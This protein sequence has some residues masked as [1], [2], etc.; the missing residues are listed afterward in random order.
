M[1]ILLLSTA[2][3]YVCK[4]IFVEL[5]N[6]GHDVSIELALNEGIIREGVELF[7]PDLVICPI[8]LT[9][10]P[11][12]VYKKVTCIIVHPGIKGDRGPSSLDWAIMDELDEWGVT[13][14]EAS[15]VFDAGDIWVSRN[16]EM[17]RASK[18]SI[19]R[20][21]VSKTAAA[22]A[23]DL[24]QKFERGGFRPEPLDYSKP[25]VKGTWRDPMKQPDRRIDWKSDT[26]DDIRKKINTA[27]GAPGLLDEI[28]GQE[29]FMYGA[30]PEDNMEGPVP[31]EVIAKRNGAICR[32]TVDGAIWITH[33]RKRKLAEQNFYKLPATVPEV[34]V[35][36][37]TSTGKRNRTFREIWYEEKNDV[38]YVYF[39]FYNGAMS[40]DQCIRMRD[41]VLAARLRKIKVIVLMGGRDFWSNGIHLN[42]IHAAQNPGDESW[43]N[44]NAIDDLVHAIITDTEHIIISAIQGSAGAGGVPLAVAADKVFCASSVIMSP[45]YKPMGDLYGSEY[46]TYLLPRRVGK[47]KGV[48]I[49]ETFMPIGVHEA[50]SIGL[51]DE[52]VDRD[53]NQTFRQKIGHMAE[54]IA[55]SPDFP[56]MIE[57]KKQ[58][59]ESDEKEKPLALYRFEELEQMKINFYGKDPAYHQARFNFVRKVVPKETPAFLAKHRR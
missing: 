6:L 54:E 16:F 18:N 58:R 26:I 39:E 44:I 46:W 14:M 10:I 7:K 40:T 23:V 30:H 50:K 33:L 19:Y 12:D 34:P 41:A 15:E 48:E 55:R 28:Y 21:E 11:E 45:F 8:L 53:E 38:G 36:L 20:D 47:E 29:F 17:R 5:R 51:I 32:A 42:V 13:L 37:M 4:H 57:D 35:N 27:D 22:C 9:K 49:T 59:R 56:K 1:R 31:G 2:Y 24:V 52:I 25:D 3:N 43:R